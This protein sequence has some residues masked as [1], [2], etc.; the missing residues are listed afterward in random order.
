LVEIRGWDLPVSWSPDVV[1]ALT[2]QQEGIVRRYVGKS[3]YLLLNLRE[4]RYDTNFSPAQIVS[5]CAEVARSKGLSLV[6]LPFSSED[7]KL[8]VET[9]AA[10]RSQG[11]DIPGAFVLPTTMAPDQLLCDIA[12]SEAVVGMRYHAGVLSM[13]AGT[14]VIG[15]GYDPK[16]AGLFTDMEQPDYFLSMSSVAEELADSILRA[17]ACKGKISEEWQNRVDVF[18]KVATESVKRVIETF[19]ITH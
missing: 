14:P 19:R 8:L 16:V 15:I 7:E 17:L 9:F 12:G 3:A 11:V 4:W 1:F 10:V 5:I 13:L 18:R 2:S 6:G